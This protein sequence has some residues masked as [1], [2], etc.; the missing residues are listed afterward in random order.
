SFVPQNVNLYATPQNDATA[1]NVLALFAQDSYSVKRFTL[2][3]GVRYEQLEGYLPSQSSPSSPFATAGVGGFAAQPREY[4]EVRD[5]VK[6]HT[7]GPRVNGVFDL[8]GDGKT[9]L[10]ASA[11]RYYYILSTGGGGVSNVNRNANYQEQYVWN[12]SNGDHKFQ[13]GEQSGTPVITAVVVNGQILTSIDQNFKRPYTDEY[14][15]GVD[16]ELMANFKL[17]VGYTYRHEKLLQATMNPDSPYASTLTSAVDPGIDGVAGT[18]DDSTY[19]FF[20]R[21]SAAN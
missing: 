16:R 20:A 2:S 5:V 17:S 4:A 1:V 13:L 18:A 8:T 3:G 15:F 14:A 19:G 10:K 11:G 12:D 9:A 6:W 21:T 7:A